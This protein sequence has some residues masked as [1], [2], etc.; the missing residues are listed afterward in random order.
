MSE[1]TPKE[2]VAELNKHIVG[3]VEAIEAILKPIII[4]IMQ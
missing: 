1:L 2:I 3:Q 4:L